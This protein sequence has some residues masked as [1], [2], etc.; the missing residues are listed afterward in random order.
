MGGGVIVGIGSDF[1]AD[2]LGLDIATALETHPDLKRS[3]CRVVACRAPAMGLPGL[4]R[5]APWAVLVDAVRGGEFGRVMRLRAEDLVG[6]AA[7]AST[8][9]FGVAA[10]LAL[11]DSLGELPKRVAILGVVVDGSAQSPDD[12]WVQIGVAAV[13][14][15][16]P[17]L[18]ASAH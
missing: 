14:A 6:D 1:G 15:E 9:G 5:G 17:R 11:L 7:P 16:L 12:E 18:A 10:T 8:H 13:L 3:R 2:R 4:L